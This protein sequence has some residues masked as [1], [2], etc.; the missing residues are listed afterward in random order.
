M[1]RKTVL[2]SKAE[3]KTQNRLVFPITFHR[4]NVEVCS[5]VKNNFSMLSRDHEI[6]KAFM[7]PPIIAYKRDKNLKDIL[8]RAIVSPSQNG[9]TTKCNRSR[10][11]TC[12]YINT[13][14]YVVGP[15]G[16]YHTKGN[17]KCTSKGLIYALE[18]KKCGQLYVGETGRMMCERFREHRRNVIN[19]KA[20]NEIASHFNENGHAL[21][22]MMICGLTFKSDTLERKICEQKI[23]AQL[24]CV[25]GGGMNTDFNFAQLLD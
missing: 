11:I 17:F 12:S 14:S 24:G 16:V 20:D 3:K 13:C 7:N 25:L 18:C 4:N 23:I 19:N 9:S 10:C 5:V 15:K 6:G 2:Y 1:D 21:S 22:D 8:V